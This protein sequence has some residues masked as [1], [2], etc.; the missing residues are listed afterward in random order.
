MTP[1]AP[2]VFIPLAA[3]W[4]A[5]LFTGCSSDAPEEVESETVVPVSTEAAQVGNIRATIHA[6]GAITPAPGAELVVVAPE[7]A[8]IA[9][10]PK[11]E[12]DA[13]ANGDVLVRF[14]I[15][16]ATAEVARQRAEL[17]RAQAQLENARAAQMRARDLFERGIAARKEVEDAD[18]DV[19]E[20]QA[21]IAQAQAALGGA[22]AAAGRAVV[23]APFSGVVAKRLHNPGD[24]VEAAAS[25]PVLRVVDPRRLEVTASIA[26]A[27][28]QRVAVGASAHLVGGSETR[29]RVVSRPAAVEQG[30]ASVPV[31]LAFAAPA[32]PLPVG[33]PVQVEIE[34][35][36]HTGVVL[37]PT[38]AIVREGEESAVF[39]AIENKAQRRVVMLG[40]VDGKHAEVRSGLEAGERVIVRGQAGLPD[41][42]TI[43]I[44]APDKPE[45]PDK[46]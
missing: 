15:P 12:G 17:I 14:E 3:L 28:V 18:R 25:D 35:D 32:A 26:I 11:G 8:R 5:F 46:P 23:R 16:S 38:P 34:A 45:A 22:E 41:G 40:I 37:V 42:A 4:G 33:T 20:A 30:T 13:V 1:R 43:T 2:F 39:V 10:I 9:D 36:E 29:L 6:T 19:A 27:D 44:D 7:P 21:A 31:R 24:L